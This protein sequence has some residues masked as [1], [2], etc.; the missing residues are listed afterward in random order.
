MDFFGNDNKELKALVKQE[1][2]TAVQEE[3]RKL[4]ADIERLYKIV[5]RLTELVKAPLK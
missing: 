1:V 3:N 5:E 2:E 4:K